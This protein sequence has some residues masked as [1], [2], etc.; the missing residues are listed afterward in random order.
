MWGD[1]RHRMGSHHRACD[2]CHLDRN[3]VAGC[4]YTTAAAIA[5]AD[6]EAVTQAWFQGLNPQLDYRSPA[7]L[8]RE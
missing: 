3:G 6:G 4:R 8:T 1:Q 7:R 5:A 2:S